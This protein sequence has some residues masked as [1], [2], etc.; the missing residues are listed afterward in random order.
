M[1]P[2]YEYFKQFFCLFRLFLFL[3]QVLG[4]KM[5]GNLQITGNKQSFVNLG[6]YLQAQNMARIDALLVMVL[7]C[8]QLFQKCLNCRTNT[9]TLKHLNKIV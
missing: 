7:L 4:Q 9:M 8:C 6:N 5:S 2:F 1:E 3:E